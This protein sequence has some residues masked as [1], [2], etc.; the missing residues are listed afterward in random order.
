[1]FKRAFNRAINPEER[2]D[3]ET[4]RGK[5]CECVSAGKRQVI[6]V[7]VI[8]RGYIRACGTGAEQPD[9]LDVL[10]RLGLQWKTR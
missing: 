2:R 7:C 4:D 5:T 1:M 8:C 3:E 6:L 10:D 9:T